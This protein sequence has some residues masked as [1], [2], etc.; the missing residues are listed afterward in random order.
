MTKLVKPFPKKSRRPGDKIFDN[1]F[2]RG[3]V[4]VV[5]FEK[6]VELDK[7]YINTVMSDCYN[8][9][10]Y[11]R[12]AKLNKIISEI[13]K[14]TKWDEAYVSKR[15]P[16]FELS[17]IF[18]YLRSRIEDTTY[19]EIEI[20]VEIADCLD[21]KYKTMYEMVPNLQKKK[22]LEELNEAFDIEKKIKTYRLF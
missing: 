18:E 5:P 15:V 1:K 13:Y 22:L 10:D 4:D 21:V 6:V 16:K 3:E 11:F 20:F 17:E 7:Q 12:I 19:S 8:A 2:N 14:G 9:Y